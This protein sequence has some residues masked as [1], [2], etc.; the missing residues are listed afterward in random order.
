VVPP[1]PANGAPLY[2]KKEPKYRSNDNIAGTGPQAPQQNPYRLPKGL[3]MP[4]PKLPTPLPKGDQELKRLDELVKKEDPSNLFINITKIGQGTF[5]EVF[6]GTDIRTLEK[7]AIKKMD[8]N[9]NYEEDLITEIEMMKTSQHS[10]IVKYVEG[11]QWEDDIW[12]I[13]EYMGGGSLTEI[14]EQFKYVQM[15]EGHIAVVC[16]ESLKALEYMHSTHRIHRDIKSDN[17]LL[18]LAG[19]IKL[20]DFGYTVQLTEKKSR[21][22]TTIGTPYWEAPEVITGDAYDTKVDIWSLGIMA[23]EMAEGEPPYM[24]LPPLA[25]LRMIVV[26]GIPP[27][28]SNKWSSE[29]RSFVSLCLSVSVTA[30]PTAA[31][32]LR[33]PFIKKSCTKVEFKKLIKK[34]R[35]IAK[36]KEQNSNVLEFSVDRSSL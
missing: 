35:E 26:D 12:V 16:F 10:N 5:G 11:Y 17:I 14:L 36:N 13:M 32:L 27:L 6:V 2:N 18:N 1:Y 8:L 20:A 33:H 9:D 7:V 24:D 30:R 29:F 3:H 25:A 4:A 31:E 21:R 15:D 19:D 23:M 28:T 22:N 34:V